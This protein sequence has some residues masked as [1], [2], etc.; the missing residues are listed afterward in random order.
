MN[1]REDWVFRGLFHQSTSDD[2]FERLSAGG[3]TTYAGFDPTGTSL[4]IGHLIPVLNLRRLQLAGNRPIALAGGGTGLIGDPSFKATER[5]ILSLSLIHI[6]ICP[7]SRSTPL[8]VALAAREEL[9]LHVRVDERSAGFFALG[10]AL[11]TKLP[12][13][14]L[15]TS[16]TAAAELHASVV[17]AS[18][19]NVA[20]LVVTADRP[21]E[22]H[23]SLI[24]ISDLFAT[25]IDDGAETTPYP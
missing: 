24:H 15:V 20:L 16:G 6:L 23:L 2:L 9:T 18:Y 17:E 7:G 5:L 25:R 21:S 10:L 3:I 11:R 4:H 8:A 12:A 22:L 14:V 13:L 1:V 19:A